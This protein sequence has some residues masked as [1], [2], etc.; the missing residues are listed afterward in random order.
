MSNTFRYVAAFVITATIFA[1]ALYVSN[2]ISDNRLTNIRAIQENMAIDI[3]S[4]E[5]QFQLLE[6]MSCTDLR[7]NSVLSRE[8]ANLS[9]R[10]SSTE[11]QLGTA[12]EEVL[13][14]KRQYSLLEIKDMLL[15][16]RVSQKCSLDPVFILYFYSNTQDAC[17]DCERQGYVLTALSE[18]YPRLRIYSFDFDLDLPALQTLKKIHVTDEQLPVL[19]INDKAS[20]G[21]KSVE[22]VEALLPALQEEE[23]QEEDPLEDASPST[24]EARSSQSR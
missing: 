3:L 4:L 21:F 14:L 1:T 17:A 12:N 6:E 16:K 8:L 24:V 11:K 13:R 2:T 7:E 18:K 22:E 9:S 15:M 23:L 10:L 5:T 20:N 19:V